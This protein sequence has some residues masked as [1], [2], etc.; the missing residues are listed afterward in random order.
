VVPDSETPEAPF[1]KKELSAGATFRLSRNGRVAWLPE[2]L[3]LLDAKGAAGPGLYRRFLD[4]VAGAPRIRTSAE[5]GSVLAFDVALRNGRALAAVNA[6][7]APL[8]VEIP[9]HAGFPMV[10]AELGAGRTLYVQSMP[11]AGDRCGGPRPAGGRRRGRLT[12]AG[13]AARF[14]RGRWTARVRADP[15]ERSC[16]VRLALARLPGEAAPCGRGRRNSAP[17]DDGAREAGAVGEQLA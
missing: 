2:P 8:A 12:R 14:C 16:A 7:D 9:G 1:A 6:S 5:E 11:R 15:G 3:E 10:Y 13:T 4:E 17:A